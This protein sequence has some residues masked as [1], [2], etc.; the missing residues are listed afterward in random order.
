MVNPT[1]TGS[2]KRK[3]TS[4]QPFEQGINPGEAPPSKRRRQQPK[5]RRTAKNPAKKGRGKTPSRLA[6]GLL[7]LLPTQSRSR[8]SGP[9]YKLS[10]SAINVQAS[11]LISV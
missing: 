11:N 8:S 1:V 3:R 9:L 7:S 6:A 10:Q 2:T 5:D 4:T